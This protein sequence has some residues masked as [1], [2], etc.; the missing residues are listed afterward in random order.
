MPSFTVD[1]SYDLAR[2]INDSAA[3]LGQP[4]E[5]W[6]GYAVAAHLEWMRL[7]GVARGAGEPLAPPSALPDVAAAL[8]AYAPHQC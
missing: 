6:L 5:V 1:L 2:E 3:A 7:H 8:C 4:V